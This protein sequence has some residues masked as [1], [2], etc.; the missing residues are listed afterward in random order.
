VKAVLR[1]QQTQI[2]E[3][4]LLAVCGNSW[5]P[6]THNPLSHYVMTH[7]VWR[8]IR[9][10]FPKHTKAN[11]IC[12]QHSNYIFVSA[13]NANVSSPFTGPTSG[14]RTFSRP[15]SRMLRLVRYELAQRKYCTVNAPKA[16][17][18]RES[19]RTYV[20]VDTGFNL[21]HYYQ[22]F[23]IYFVYVRHIKSVSIHSRRTMDLVQNCL[24]L[25]QLLNFALRGVNRNVRNCKV[26]GV[27]VRD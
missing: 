5:R 17:R 11:W 21:F 4:T 7:C 2:K 3:I 24:K 25:H 1:R 8:E 12:K 6:H 20:H 16:I 18:N 19:T 22:L 26:T 27:S 10:V 23:N 15:G 13:V 9:R 14:P